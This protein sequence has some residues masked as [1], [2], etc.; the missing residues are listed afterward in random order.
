MKNATAQKTEMERDEVS[1]DWRRDFMKPPEK[2][3]RPFKFADGARIKTT[4]EVRLSAANRKSI[5][6]FA[7]SI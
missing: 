5:G 1:A 4:C 6:L 7:D 3:V 2:S